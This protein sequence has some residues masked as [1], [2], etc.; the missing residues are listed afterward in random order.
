M[1][2]KI[3][4]LMVSMMAVL[5][6][7]GGGTVLAVEI[8]STVETHTT[9]SNAI[10]EN[11]TICLSEDD[12]YG[13]CE[14]NEIAAGIPVVPGEA[15]TVYIEVSADDGNGASDMDDA[16]GAVLNVLN[17]ADGAFGSVSL[18]V[19][20]S[21]SN[22]KT[23]RGTFDFE[24]YDAPSNADISV[25]NYTFVLNVSDSFDAS[26][27]ETMDTRY[28]SSVSLWLGAESGVAVTFDKDGLDMSPG[29]TSDTQ[30]LTVTNYGNVE[31][32]VQLSGVQMDRTTGGASI[33]VENIKYFSASAP[34]CGFDV[35]AT[36]LTGTPTTQHGGFDL[37]ISTTG[38]GDTG[39][40]KDQCFNL[41]VPAAQGPGDYVGIMTVSGIAA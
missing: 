19:E 37:P 27:E 6:V 5:F 32:N 13:V 30:T 26:A 4:S 2:I 8:N 16:T 7:I 25:D 14:Y 33:P 17:P 31:L 28:Q 40:Q 20:S 1:K 35:P 3:L 12:D 41:D 24:Y 11:L 29:Q 23:W 10:P 9:I 18:T 22:T 36:S 21:S 34:D 15:R 39:A 38:T